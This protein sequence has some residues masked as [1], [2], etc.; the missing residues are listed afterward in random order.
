MGYAH[1]AKLLYGALLL[2]CKLNIILNGKRTS[3]RWYGWH[4]KSDLMQD[5][6]AWGWRAAIKPERDA[7]RRGLR[8]ADNDKI[9]RK[10]HRTAPRCCRCP[11]YFVAVQFSAEWPKIPA[12]LWIWIS[13]VS[14]HFAFSFNSSESIRLVVWLHNRL[15][16]NQS[17]ASM[18]PIAGQCRH[19]L[20]VL[21]TVSVALQ[22]KSHYIF[23]YTPM[24]VVFAAFCRDWYCAVCLILL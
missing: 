16:P 9:S 10:G 17:I 22:G 23:K 6:R 8:L 2:G 13:M 19:P 4:L 3:L 24:R 20:K 5:V 18:P 7:G 12:H 21:Y 15:M 11:F 1:L 14:G